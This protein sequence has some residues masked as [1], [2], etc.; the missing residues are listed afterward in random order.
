MVGVGLIAWALSTGL[1]TQYP[2]SRQLSTTV[3]V[4]G[5]LSRPEGLSFELFGHP[6]GIEFAIVVVNDSPDTL[7]FAASFTTSLG[8]R[9]ERGGRVVPT[10]P[11][12]ERIEVA[13]PDDESADVSSTVPFTVVPQGVARFHGVLTAAAS[14]A[15]GA[16]DYAMLLDLRRS[17]AGVRDGTGHPWRGYFGEEGSIAIRVTEPRTPAEQRRANLAAATAAMLKGDAALALRHFSE[18]LRADPNDI[19]AQCGSGQAYL[20]LRRFREAAVAFERVIP[21]LPRGERSTIYDD[22]AFAYLALGEDGR[23]EAILADKYGAAAAKSR[24]ARLREAARKR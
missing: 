9:V 2:P 11:A 14:P 3:E 21:R 24:L 17:V 8:L 12:W 7:I 16:G 1:R 20:D 5:G 18:M 22:A 4:K 19:D 15:F 6:A 13:L 10:T 23:A